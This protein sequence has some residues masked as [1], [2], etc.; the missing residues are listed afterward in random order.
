MLKVTYDILFELK[1]EPV[2]EVRVTQKG[3]EYLKL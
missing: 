3:I 1:R 2:G